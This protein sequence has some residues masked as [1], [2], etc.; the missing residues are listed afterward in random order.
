MKK[1]TTIVSLVLLAACGELQV[2]GGPS[3]NN[4]TVGNGA[5]TCSGLEGETFSSVEDQPL[6]QRCTFDADMN[7]QC[8]DIYGA[9]DIFFDD[10]AFYWTT[11]QNVISGTYTC[12]NG[13]ITAE[14]DGNDYDGSFGGVSLTWEGLQYRR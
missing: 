4:N 3:Q 11:L 10:G 7:Y 1:A 6:D 9:W 5:P 2:P 13:T 14:A 8:T 12:R